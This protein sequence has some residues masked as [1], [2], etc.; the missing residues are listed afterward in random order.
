ME[1]YLVV[2][3]A[4]ETLCKGLLEGAWERTSLD[5]FAFHSLYQ[6]VVGRV[7][8]LF[9]LRIGIVIFTMGGL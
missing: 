2:V 3:L 9:G 8:I 7:E 4:A 5:A 1:P 6:F